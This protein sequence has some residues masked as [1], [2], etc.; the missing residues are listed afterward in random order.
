MERLGSTGLTENTALVRLLLLCI[1]SFFFLG[2]RR[3]FRASEVRKLSHPFGLMRMNV[4]MGDS[5]GWASKARP[6]VTSFV[7]QH[8]LSM[9]SQAIVASQPDTGLIKSWDQQ[10]IFLQSDDG[11]SY[12]EEVYKCREVLRDQ[13]KEN[14]WTISSS[15][16]E[17]PRGGPSDCT[18]N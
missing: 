3:L 7:S 4:V 13:M 6:S 15:N 12:R 14:S 2:L 1:G 16:P 11:A 18:G 5:E 8:T 17:K 9:V 10:K